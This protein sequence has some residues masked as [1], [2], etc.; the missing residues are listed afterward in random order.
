M[1]NTVIGELN[2]TN[3]EA[4][5]V[6]YILHNGRNG[7]LGGA[8]TTGSTTGTTTG[9]TGATGTTSGTT[10]TTTGG[11]LNS[12]AYS[13]PTLNLGSLL[14]NSAITQVVTAGGTGG[15]SGFVTAGNTLSALVTALQSTDRFRVVSRPSIFTTNNKKATIADGEEIAV[16]TNITGGFAG[17]TTAG[18]GLVTQSS[19]TFKE[20]ALTLEVLP[21]INSDKEVTLDIVQKEDQVD[22]S[23]T[24]DNN[25]IPTISTRVLK[26]TV[27]V[28]NLGTLVL[29]GL[30][31]QSHDRSTSGVPYLSKIPYLGALFRSTTNN[32]TRTELVILIR[33][34]V[35]IDP[36][37]NFKLRERELEYLEGHP[38][39]D[40][41]LYPANL[42]K[43]APAEPEIRR[44]YP[45]TPYDK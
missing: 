38:D 1:L 2:L 37:E 34:V 5:G 7:A 39:L 15:L 8:S 12:G 28:P 23:T 30:I 35:T 27:T 42:R 4:F 32:K 24:I 31:K 25:S 11:I 3:N 26:T 22:G 36:D 21:L 29:G 45:A 41:T 17:G 14:G 9:T 44:A 43:R 16:P 13:S 20:V 6:D 18:A 19:V 10:A 40:G 33:P